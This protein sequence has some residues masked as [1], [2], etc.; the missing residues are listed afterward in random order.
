MEEAQLQTMEEKKPGYKKTKLG[1]IPEDWDISNLRNATS[2]LTNGFVGK[3]KDHYCSSE[4]GVL[5]IQGFNVTL[6][7]FNFKDIKYVTKEFHFKK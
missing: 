4:T 7:S 2:L 1:W 3:A 6:N 5:Y